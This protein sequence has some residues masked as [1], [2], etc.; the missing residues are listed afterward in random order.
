MRPHGFDGF[1]GFD[2][3][4]PKFSSDLTAV[5]KKSVYV[6][7]R[8]VETNLGALDSNYSICVMPSK[9]KASMLDAH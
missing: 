4:G 9:R 6:C 8:G 5:A 1:D 3:L 7:L 2:M